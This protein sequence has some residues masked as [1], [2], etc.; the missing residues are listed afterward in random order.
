M[1]PK[2]GKRG[3]PKKIK[4]VEGE[5][6]D[7][8]LVN[9]DVE[10]SGDEAIADV[11]CAKEC[12]IDYQVSD[13]VLNY[14]G[15]KMDE[16]SQQSDLMMNVLENIENMEPMESMESIVN[17]DNM[18]SMDNDEG[19]DFVG[20]EDD[21]S[22]EGVESKKQKVSDETFSKD[23]SIND[24]DGSA[25]Y[26]P[27]ME[28]SANSP[29]SESSKSDIK[30]LEPM[31]TEPTDVIINTGNEGFDKLSRNNE[32]NHVT[33]EHET[34][35]V[36]E[37]ELP[38]ETTKPPS[39]TEAV[40]DD[41]LPPNNAADHLLDTE[42]VSEDELPP[43]KKRKADVSTKD[44]KQTADSKSKLIEDRTINQSTDQSL[45]TE[46]VSEDEL[47][48]VKKKKKDTDGDKDK[49]TEPLEEDTQT[50]SS[51]KRSSSASESNEGSTSKK[52]SDSKSNKSLLELEKYWKAVR[53]DPSDFTGWTYLLQYVDQG[54]D[55]DAARE[56]YDAFLSHYPYCY[57]YWR[58]Y[59][60]YEKKKGE[61][62]KSQEVFERGLAAIP[63]SVDLWLHYLNHIKN[64]H[65]EDEDYIRQQYDR[66]IDVCGIEFRSDRLWDSYI[67]WET[68]CK[69]VGNVFNIYD[70]L[71]TVP[72]QG[73]KGHFENFVD[74]VK[75][76]QPNKMLNVDEFL[77]M[78]AEVLQKLKQKGSSDTI[79]A[80]N[81]PPGDESDQETEKSP[82][83]ADEETK[84]MR[85]KIISLRTKAFKTMSN[86]VL[87][88]WNYEEG[89]K[90]PYFHVK[91][92]ERCQL[93]NWRS[94]L[95]Y[96][97]S[98][99][100]QDRTIVLFERCLIACALYDEFWFKY[101]KY[102]ETLTGE[103][104]TEKIRNV[105]MR[106]CTI[107]HPKKPLLSLNWASFEENHGNIDAARQILVRLEK[108]VSNS[109]QISIC[110]I[111]LERR[112]QRFEEVSKLYEHYISTNKNKFAT[113]AL[114]I[115][116]A[117]FCQ[118]ILNDVNKGSDVLRKAI[119][120]DKDNPR[121]YHQLLDLIFSKSPREPQHE[122]ECVSIIDQ[123]LERESTD[124]EHKLL[125]AQHKVEF[126]EDFG[127][128]MT[129]VQKA[130]TDYM[131]LLKQVKEKRRK[132]FEDKIKTEEKKNNKT[133]SS[134]PVHPAP[135]ASNG[136][137]ST[138]VSG[139]ATFSTSGNNSYPNQQQAYQNS[140]NQYQQSANYGQPTYNQYSNQ[141]DASYNN[142]QSWNYQQTPGYNN[143]NQGWGS[144][145][146]Y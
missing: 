140:S 143:Y 127:S 115:K 120:K 48:P 105:Y 88:R 50:K 54:Q 15:K 19:L 116:Y 117:R 28:D 110:R 89:I 40:S 72:T 98:Q 134:V 53:E 27:L 25:Q 79:P 13:E 129:N 55:V 57:G 29:D 144:Y 39:D 36:S 41:E 65:K 69:N 84:L 131:N 102:L 24:E 70:K 3:R 83:F 5:E 67:K 137:N 52:S 135:A 59:A 118:K 139:S 17:I 100:D 33:L 80:A 94:Y 16:L 51:H 49:K 23:R 95:E 20:L 77:S 96:E 18:D 43:I 108:E 93:N 30:D 85:D 138:S 146:Y 91:P 111:N 61:K 63:L 1:P 11:T 42:A 76:N 56:A 119:E 114:S 37:D 97:I 32:E 107:H 81:A 4:E 130:V 22:V 82:T 86:A 10:E 136:S 99:G 58:K 112:C 133:E 7:T 71:L 45:D 8:P 21:T 106:A 44:K 92:L 64:A 73:Y 74:F 6:V 128:S 90:R 109:L 31:E 122:E 12:V 38:S 34:E 121:L 60:D 78:R 26:D 123:F 124:I 141:S 62:T 35:T 46:A 2:R 87:V 132:Q 125:F 68:D 126:L 14:D 113:N 142:Y 47:P 103:D 66:A 75:A 9:E 145:N 101:V 104:I